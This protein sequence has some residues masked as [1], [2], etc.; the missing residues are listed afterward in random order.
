MESTIST[1]TG[2]AR[3]GSVLF[4]NMKIYFLRPFLAGIL[5]F[6]IALSTLA[7]TYF[8]ITKFFNTGYFAID[9]IDLVI[10]FVIG[11]VPLSICFSPNTSETE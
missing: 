5:G 2:F 11:F 4:Y 8:I 1:A 6:I 3:P 7:L 10:A 9:S